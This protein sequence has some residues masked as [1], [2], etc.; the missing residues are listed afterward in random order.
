M[1]EHR[2]ARLVT[3]RVV[4]L[5]EAVEVEQ[6]QRE[7]GPAALRVQE[8]L[9]QAVVEETAVREPGQRVEE[10]KLLDLLNLG[11]QPPR[12]LIQQREERQV[13]RDQYELQHADHGQEPLAAGLR[14][15]PVVLSEREH[16]GRLVGADERY[17]DKDLQ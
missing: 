15:R 13:E 14:D 4:D 3:E 12:D 2:I 11:A 7:T 6:H 17:G 9:L 1:L 10:R 16:P 8:R 5:L